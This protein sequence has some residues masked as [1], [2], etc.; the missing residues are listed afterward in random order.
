MPDAATAAEGAAVNTITDQVFLPVLRKCD[1]RNA[2]ARSK[3]ESGPRIKIYEVV[4]GS[5][6]ESLIGRL[7]MEERQ[8]VTEG[9]H[10]P[11]ECGLAA[12]DNV[13]PRRGAEVMVEVLRSEGVRYV[14][15]N[16]GTTELPFIDA[17]TDREDL[18]YV[19]GLQEAAVV[20][21]GDGYAQAS[22]RPAFINLHTVGGLGHAMGAL[23]NAKA[24]RTPLVVTAG[25]QDTRHAFAEPLLHG[26]LLT[27]ARPA[28]KWA[29]E[30]T[31]PDQIAV[32]LRRAF[33]ESRAA[34]SGPTLLSLPMDVLEGT[35]SGYITPR[36]VIAR[37]S[38]A[39]ALPELANALASVV[40]GRLAMIA[41]DEVFASDA[42]RETVAVAELLG[43]A[44]FGPSWPAYLP[45][46]T[47]HA[48]WAGNL[49]ITTA[50]IRKTLEVFDAVFVL[51]GNFADAILYTEDS[52]V[53][54]ACKLFQLSV[55]GHNLGR[56][57]ATDLACVGDIRESLRVLLPMLSDAV[58]DKGAAVALH[59]K[60]QC[61]LKRRRAAL[62]KRV[63]GDLARTV[64]T[65]LAAAHEVVKGLGTKI[66]LVDESPTTMPLIRRAFHSPNTRQYYGP[67][68]A[69]L[70][71]G[72]GAAVGVSL[73]L[74]REP[75]V[76]LI[77]DGSALY[78]PQ[79]LWTAARERLPVTFVVLNNRSYAILKN[80]MKAKEN[81]AS[82]KSNRI[83]GMDLIN[84]AI[85]FAELALSMGV[86]ARRVDRTGEIAM[87]VERG[88]ASGV[89]NLVEIPVCSA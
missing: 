69:I 30:A 37:T 71:W 53:P 66:P 19:L 47:S 32:L 10:S 60:A 73:A 79:A 8:H 76:A 61:E 63:H 31:H 35:A 59:A 16:P 24:A 45:F 85:G 86:E 1:R 48:L 29:H 3:A 75:V 18:N 68:G 41:G 78:A 12:I 13:S 80:F 72:M 4:H 11:H 82:S 58:S 15:G 39:A 57:Y 27:L 28:V 81:Y 22:G 49:P 34:P 54:A 62:A 46:P 38:V 56:T 50:S 70:G 43:A 26:D 14:F 52:A 6:C 21:M 33:H 42:S 23:M 40:P 20:A 87:A 17:L 89:P 55:D 77:G 2:K 74:G 83:I 25:Q 44:V 5:R 67:R 9:A 64:T 51:G 7:V 84:P 36:S 65:P 88:I